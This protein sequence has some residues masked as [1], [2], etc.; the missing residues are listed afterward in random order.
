M[1]VAKRTVTKIQTAQ[2]CAVRKFRP[3]D[4][5][6][7]RYVGMSV[8]NRKDDAPV[9]IMM[10]KSSNPPHYMVMDGMYKQMYYLRYADAVDYCKRMRYIRSRN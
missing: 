4:F 8:I 6:T 1:T 2:I 7:D 5:D 3:I 9:L 10:S